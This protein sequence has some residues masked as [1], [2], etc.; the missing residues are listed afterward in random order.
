MA[1]MA[2]D[3]FTHYMGLDF[4]EVVSFLSIGFKGIG[5]LQVDLYR[6]GQKLE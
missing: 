3:E 6:K 2:E 4:H 5:L 1:I